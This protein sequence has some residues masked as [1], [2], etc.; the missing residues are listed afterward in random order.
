MAGDLTLGKVATLIQEVADSTAALLDTAVFPSRIH[1]EDEDGF[2]EHARYLLAMKN[3]TEAF[4]LTVERT[5][6]VEE[7]P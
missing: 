4:G 5:T 3:L 2:P 1:S 7:R 6:A